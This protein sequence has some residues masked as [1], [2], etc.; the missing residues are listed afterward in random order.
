M[1]TYPPVLNDYLNKLQTM[2]I[3]TGNLMPLRDDP[4]P[5]RNYSVKEIQDIDRRIK[6]LLNIAQNTDGA[7]PQQSGPVK[8]PPKPVRKQTPSPNKPKEPIENTESTI[9]RETTPLGISDDNNQNTESTITRETTPLGISDDNNLVG[10]AETE[11]GNGLVGERPG[12][13]LPQSAMRTMAQT[14]QSTMPLRDR[15]SL[16]RRTA[17][18]AVDALNTMRDNGVSRSQIRNDKRAVRDARRT[19]NRGQPVSEQQFKDMIK[20]ILK[21]TLNK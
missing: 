11:A 3:N 19:I 16:N 1:R 5:H 14:A 13:T 21:E 15:Q 2:G 17:Q 12:L 20:E 6:E 9:T 4:R 8:L 18:N 7:V 10:K